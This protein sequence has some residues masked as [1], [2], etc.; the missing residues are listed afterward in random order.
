[1]SLQNIQS[2]FRKIAREYLCMTFNVFERHFCIFMHQISLI[3]AAYCYAPA[4]CHF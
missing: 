3:Y 4:H 1:M 2:I